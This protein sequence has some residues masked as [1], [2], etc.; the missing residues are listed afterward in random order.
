MH[1]VN[2]LKSQSD[3]SLTPCFLFVVYQL[4][5]QSIMMVDMIESSNSNPN[6]VLD[7]YG[8]CCIL[9]DVEILWSDFE[10]I[11]E[12]KGDRQNTVLH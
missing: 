2:I 7:E 3:Y 4:I 6:I 12:Y 9:G 1:I 8:D 5:G 10:S 11:I